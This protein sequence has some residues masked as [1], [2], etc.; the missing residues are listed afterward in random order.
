MVPSSVSI[1][2]T[3][4]MVEIA[5][6]VTCT[7]PHGSRIN[8]QGTKQYSACM[9]DDMLVEIDTRSLG[10]SRHFML[11]AGK[12]H[13]M[14]GAPGQHMAA[15]GEAH[16]MNH[17]AAAMAASVSCSPTWAQPSANG[18]RIFVACN[19]SNDIVE[20]DASTWA[21][22]RRIPAGNGIYNLGASPDGKLLI[23]TNKRDQSVSIFDTQSG[24]EL[25]RVKTKRKIVHGVVIS[26]DSRYAFITVEGIGSEPGTLEVIDLQSFQSVATVDLGQQAAGLDFFK[27]EPAK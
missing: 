18:S 11:G 13:G 9:M 10:V 19:K 12:E 16:A 22:V 26:P 1:V 24:K 6:P 2:S 14:D 7:M 25:S 20:I 15:G 5:R 21:L 27:E 3:D 8:P 17:D 23:G 4:E